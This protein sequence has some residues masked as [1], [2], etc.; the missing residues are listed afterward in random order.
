MA[1]AISSRGTNI[2]ISQSLTFKGT[3]VI[4]DDEKTKQWMYHELANDVRRGN[5]D[6]AAAFAEHL[7]NSP[8]RIVIEV[9]PDKTIGFD[10][11]AMFRNSPT[12]APKTMLD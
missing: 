11:D 2:G 6:Q 7:G 5:P 9:I 1:I 4:H 8:G 3:A 12:G 10:S